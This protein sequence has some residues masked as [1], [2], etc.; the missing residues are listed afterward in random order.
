MAN[1]KGFDFKALAG[2]VTA[3]SPVIVGEKLS[4]DDVISLGEVTPVMCDLVEIG[5]KP[6]AVFQFAEVDQPHHYFGGA[7]LTKIV[8][9]WKAAFEGSENPDAW[10]EP[11]GVRFKLYKGKTKANRDVTL[12]DIL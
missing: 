1:V 12:V 8:C 10:M 11:N 5:D 3:G 4:T 9:A 2:S 6:V 7:L